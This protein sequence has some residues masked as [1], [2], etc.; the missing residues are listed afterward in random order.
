MGEA[1]VEVYAISFRLRTFLSLF[2]F[3][4]ICLTSMCFRRS[5]GATLFWFV[6]VIA[7]SSMLLEEKILMY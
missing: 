3:L 7:T 5:L 2:V 4:I 1:S 6:E